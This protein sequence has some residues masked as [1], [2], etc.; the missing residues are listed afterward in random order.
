MLDYAAISDLSPAPPGPLYRWPGLR[1]PVG[2]DTNSKVMP[3]YI[4]DS[5]IKSL[6]F[7]LLSWA[8]I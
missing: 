8:I 6:V 3:I 2:C 4:V 7:W 1:V 5:I